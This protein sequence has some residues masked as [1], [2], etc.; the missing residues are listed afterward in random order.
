[1]FV[2]AQK[3]HAILHFLS[4]G[5]ATLEVK[6]RIEVRPQADPKAAQAI[7]FRSEPFRTPKTA[8]L[9]RLRFRDYA[10][11]RIIFSDLQTIVEP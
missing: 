6:E 11:I 1:V 8:L 7:R 3:V 4:A 2:I 10:N 9:D 5:F